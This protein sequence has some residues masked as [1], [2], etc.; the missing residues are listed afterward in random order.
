MT[1]SSDATASATVPITVNPQPTV[2]IADAGV[3]E[4][5]IAN[6]VVTLSAVSTH[7]IT[8]NYATGDGSAVAPGDY[9][10]TSGTLTIPAGSCGPTTT[11][12]LISV[13]TLD[14]SAFESSE[15]YSVNL[16]NPV[17][18]VI[19]DGV[20]TGTI[21]DNDQAPVL[22]IANSARLE[23]NEGSPVTG[24]QTWADGGTLTLNNA[25]GMP[26]AASSSSPFYLISPGTT[27]AAPSASGAYRGPFTYLGKN[28]NTLLNVRPA[29]S[30]LGGQI[31][32]RPSPMSFTVLLC[33]A[34]SGTDADH[35][36][37]TT[38]GQPTVVQFA[39][40]NGVSDSAGH[41][42]VKSGQ[43]YVAACSVSNATGAACSGPVSPPLTIPAGATSGTIT[44]SLIPNKLL[45]DTTRHFGMKLLS[46][47][48]ATVRWGLGAGSII[49]DDFT[50]PPTA[51]TG[52]VLGL[53]ATGATIAATANAQ[54][55]AATTYIEYGPSAPAYGSK[56]ASQGLPVDFNDH[57][58][59][60]SLTGLAPST[61]Y[62]YRVSRPV[63]TTRPPTATTRPLRP[64][65]LRLHR[66][67]LHRLLLRHRHHRRRHHHSLLW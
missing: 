1:D 16:L 57:S 38:S 55:E 41:V 31:A 5:Q 2:N 22:I 62:H 54:G 29:G 13:Q 18:T 42:P 45:Q 43:D 51:S 15:T 28:G 44:V 67:L 63:R 50:N 61:T 23:G 11:N 36:I 24:P 8:V 58:L 4:G 64:R 21:F 47:T 6:F 27:Q 33:T 17:G 56:S 59:T 10:T 7:N 48:G 9:T 46:A 66:L 49:D 32:F 19:G 34:Q 37:S 20:G 25:S 14:D 12:C 40:L 60:F 65:R 30:A 52:D 35:C 3:T 39:T 53:N 26:N